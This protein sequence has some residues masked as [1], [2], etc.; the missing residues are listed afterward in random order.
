MSNTVIHNV[1]EMQASLP[2]KHKGIRAAQPG[3]A[4][5]DAASLYLDWGQSPHHLCLHG[6]LTGTSWLAGSPWLRH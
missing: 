5:S 4:R 3:A 2:F 1:Q 6:H